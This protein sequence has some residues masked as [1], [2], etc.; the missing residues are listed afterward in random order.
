MNLTIVIPALNE[1]KAIRAI[2]ERALA[3]KPLIIERAGIDQVHIVVVNDGSTDSTP[4]I[5]ASIDGI[6]LIS[7]EKNKGYGAAIKLGFAQF[8]TELVSFLDADG[9][10]DPLFFIDLINE[11]KEKDLDVVLGS[12]LGTESK[13][14][15]IRRFGNVLFALL[16]RILSGV[17]VQDTASGMRVIRR[18]ALKELYPLPDGLHFTPAMSARAIFNKKLKIGEIPMSYEERV[19]ESKLNPLKDGIRFLRVII[20]MAVQYSPSFFFNGI[21]LLLV[22]IASILSIPVF[23]SLL[24]GTALEPWIFYRLLTAFVLFIAGVITFC[25]GQIAKGFLRIIHYSGDIHIIKGRIGFVELIFVRH[26]LLLGLISLLISITIL[27]GPLFERIQTG[28][29]TTTWVQFILGQFFF[30]LAFILFCIGGLGIIQNSVTE[31]FAQ[32]IISAK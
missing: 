19:G 12:R 32:K 3:A 16:L 24:A 18:S 23:H 10:C 25:A 30:M 31:N 28:E 8:D 29:M 26:G 17:S 21:S 20:E 6:D 14:P 27:Y 7:Y 22:V 5:A 1:E 13:M 9:T 2:C 15:L 4:V 11:L